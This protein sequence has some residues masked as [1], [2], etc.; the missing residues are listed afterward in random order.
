MVKWIIENINIID[1]TFLTSRKIVIGSSIPQDLKKMYHI[2]NPH[3][4]Y[5]KSFLE[6]FASDNKVEPNPIRQW[7][8]YQNKHKHEKSGMY[9]LY[10]LT[11][12]YCYV[13]TMMS[14]LFRYSNI[15]KFLFEWV[16]LLRQHHILI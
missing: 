7:I 9:S 1:R 11:S 3:K 10:S 4:V 8:S 6:Q 13:G 12:P 15:V 5:G 2:P 14:R 16:L